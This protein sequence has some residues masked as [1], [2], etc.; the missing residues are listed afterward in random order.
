[1]LGY[2]C[3]SYDL[4]YRRDE[5]LTVMS[6]F[7]KVEWVKTYYSSLAQSHM[8]AVDCH[9]RRDVTDSWTYEYQ[10]GYNITQSVVWLK[11]DSSISAVSFA[12]AHAEAHVWDNSS[13]LTIIRSENE[14]APE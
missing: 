5:C 4:A 6:V 9:T 12:K 11:L 7:D 13:D 8:Y 2:Y 14:H 10:R 1:M 3:I